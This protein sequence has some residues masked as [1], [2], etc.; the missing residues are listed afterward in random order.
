MISP[1]IA[2][3]TAPMRAPPT[4]AYGSTICPTAPPARA[5]KSVSSLRPIMRANPATTFNLDSRRCFRTYRY[6]VT[7]P[8]PISRAPT[9]ATTAQWVDDDA[10]IVIGALWI[11][12][13]MTNVF[14]IALRR[15]TIVASVRASIKF[16][17]VPMADAI[18]V[19]SSPSYKIPNGLVGKSSASDLKY[20]SVSRY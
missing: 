13:W 18:A 2:P 15:T 12:S 1:K 17:T 14:L 6:M 4:G 3:V 20:P 10:D 8:S 9:R 19:L 7:A 5:N 16:Q 11:S